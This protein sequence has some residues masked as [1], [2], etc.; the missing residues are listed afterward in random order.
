MS[1][2]SADV[3]DQLDQGNSAIRRAFMAAIRAILS[4]VSAVEVEQLLSAGRY[5]DVMAAIG[6]NP[7]RLSPV[8][9]AVRE[10]F[11]LAGEQ[12]AATIRSPGT[13]LRM[14]FDMR[15]PAAEQWLKQ[16][17]ADLVTRITEDQRAA[18]RTVLEAGMR[19]G[20]NPRKV[21]LDIIG[22]IDKVT[23][24]RIGGIVGLNDQLAQYVL[25]AR[26]ELLSGNP[27]EMANYFT[28]VLRDR[29]FDGVVRRAMAAGEPVASS[30]VDQIVARYADRLL[31][32]RGETIARTEGL[33][34][35]NSARELS[36]AQ[37]VSEGTIS[38][39]NVTKSWETAHDPR[40]RESHREMQGQQVQG[41]GGVFVTGNGAWMKYPGDASLGAGPED[42]C[43]CRCVASYRVSWIRQALE[44]EAA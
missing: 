20:Q 28:R 15:N 3:I 4:A 27:A 2:A 33:A 9:D 29:R 6:L 10:A 19:A 39:Q 42:I 7:A 21:A 13:K 40:V 17:A 24:R 5:G 34:A 14:Q 35:L 31:Q 41:V 1:A 36:Y 12:E 23:G 11:K 26:T 16:E 38:A 43:N 37:A 18:L 22:R 30:D 8:V 44:R 25:N 32:L